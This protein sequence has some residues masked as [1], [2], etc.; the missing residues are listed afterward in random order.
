MLSWW[1]DPSPCKDADGI[2]ADGAVRSGKTLCMS[3][4][5][6]LWAMHR[7]DGASFAMCGK[8]VNSLKRNVIYPLLPILRSRGFHIHEK[9]TEGVIEIT[10]KS[11]ANRFYMFGGGDELSREKI[12]GMTLGGVLFDE[13][14]L[15]AESFVN[16]AAAR[17]SLPGSKFWFN[18]NPEG[19]NHW[20]K[21][22]WID[23]DKNLVY[24]HFTMD[25]NLSLSEEVKMRYRR[26][27]SGVFYNRFILGQWVAADGVEIM[28]RPS[29]EFIYDT[30]FDES[31]SMKKIVFFYG[32]N[33]E[34]DK[35]DQRF[36][37]QKFK[38]CGGRCYITEAIYDGNGN[39]KET[40]HDFDD[41]GLDFIPAYIIVNDPLTGDLKGESDVAELISNQDRYN[42]LKSDDAD[43]LMFHMFP[44]TV[45]KNA[46]GDCLDN[47]RIAPNAIID[48]QTDQASNGDADIEKLESGFSYSEAYENSIN[49][50]KSDMYDLMDVP[51]IT[52]EQLSGV[53]QSGKAM[54]ALY[55]E[56]ICKCEERW[57]S[58]DSALKWLVNA[59]IK[60]NSIYG[61]TNLPEADFTVKI[62]HLYPIMEDEEAERQLDLTEVSAGVRSR[63]N[64]IE[65]WNVSTD[66]E[67]EIDTFA[68]EKEILE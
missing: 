26:M 20:F 39:I 45:A 25:D 1:T 67:V 31:D 52:T 38:L 13:A 43:T 37:K 44:V 33:N 64:Y 19:P 49:R 51:Y 7:F 65:K 32:L 9:M 10:S 3:L 63:K 40:I 55:C 59:I 50:V 56:L 34:K 42:H 53:I 21:K 8:T 29:F 47:M 17:C 6:V 62:E 30:E 60:I 22:N 12:Q 35:K 54:K 4:S 15:L 41:T 18:C 68:K 36:W 48:L 28:F 2:I 57:R 5:F 58:W 11:S 16:Q 24:L 14:A 23:A 46:S 61:Y 27:Y 66:G